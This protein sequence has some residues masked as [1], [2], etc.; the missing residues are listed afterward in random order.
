MIDVYDF[1]YKKF[2]LFY[3]LQNMLDFIII[4]DE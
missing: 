3:I 1:G 2:I 4:I